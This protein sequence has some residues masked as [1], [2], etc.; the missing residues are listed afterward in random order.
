[1]HSFAKF[2]EKQLPSAFTS[3]NWGKNFPR[4]F[5]NMHKMSGQHSS[6]TCVQLQSHFYINIHTNRF[7]IKFY[8]LQLCKSMLYP[9]TFMRFPL[10]FPVQHR[11]D[12]FVK[13]NY[14]HLRKYGSQFCLTG[15]SEHL[16]QDI[17]HKAA[18]DKQQRLQMQNKEVAG[19]QSNNCNFLQKNE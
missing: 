10:P 1:M 18:H 3:S 4:R 19:H 8:F 16:K 6:L 12:I 17:S 13:I 2:G 9:V 15:C 11:K 5:I 7:S 14:L